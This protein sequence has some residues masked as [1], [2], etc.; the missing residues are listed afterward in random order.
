MCFGRSLRPQVAR[1]LHKL[2]DTI[3]IKWLHEPFHTTF[4]MT[5][6]PLTHSLRW[7]MFVAD[8]D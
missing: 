6:L 1:W 5:I 4:M 8:G 2:T 3:A 7:N